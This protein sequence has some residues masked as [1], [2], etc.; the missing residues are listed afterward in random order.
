MSETGR[1]AVNK[2]VEENGATL[3]HAVKKIRL[4]TATT[5]KMQRLYPLFAK[6]LS[7]MPKESDIIAF[8]TEMAFEWFISSGEIEKRVLEIAKK[9]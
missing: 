7:N 3:D 6:N 4:R 8:M 1:D 5:E 9:D 2:L